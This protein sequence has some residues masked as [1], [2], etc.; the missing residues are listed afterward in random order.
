MQGEKMLEKIISIGETILNLIDKLPLT[1]ILVGVVV[2]I[3][4][5]WISYYLAERAIR[6]KE[7]NRLYIQVEIIKKELKANDE[8]LNKYIDSVNEMNKMEK[9]L[10]LPLSSMKQFLISILDRLQEIKLN[11]TH[12]RQCIFEKPTKVCLLVQKIEDID[13]AI[14]EKMGQGYSDKYLDEKRKEQISKLTEE[15][16]Q[17]IKE[18][19]A[20]KDVDIYKE[21]LT[22]QKQLEKLMVGDVFGKIEE[23]GDNF[24]LAKYLYDRIRC[25]NE[26]ADKTKDHVLALYEDLVIFKIDSDIV[27]DGCFDQDKFDLYYKSSENPEGIHARLY[28][29]CEKYYKWLALKEYVASYEFDFMD[30]RWQENCTDFVIINDRELYVSLVELYESLTEDMGSNFEEKYKYCVIHHDEIQGII[31]QLGQH[32]LKIKKKCK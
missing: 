10:E 24:A 21:F 11:Y 23:Q 30:K 28:E 6:K 16:E 9:A 25:F 18:I 31:K 2:P 17:Y 22:L 7:N 14:D 27:K 29:L 20:I 3:M 32:E 19:K 26:K 15:K 1:D 8:I 12:S 4:S 13:K 5:A